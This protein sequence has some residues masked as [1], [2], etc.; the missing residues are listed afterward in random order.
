MDHHGISTALQHATADDMSFPA[1][2][3][4]ANL[5]EELAQNL[6]SPEAATQQLNAWNV[7]T[8]FQAQY[9]ND[10]LS[11]PWQLDLGGWEHY[12]AAPNLMPL[13]AADDINSNLVSSQAPA[14]D[15]PD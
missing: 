2:S 13:Q 6:P 1:F 12:L 7:Q 9:N 14:S 10:L 8:L 3:Q 11:Q 5:D 4:S 15:S